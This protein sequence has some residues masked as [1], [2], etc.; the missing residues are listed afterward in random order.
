MIAVAKPEEQARVMR[1]TIGETINEIRTRDANTKKTPDHRWIVQNAGDFI[2]GI[3]R[4]RR[5]NV[6]KPKDISPGGAGSGVHLP[7]AAGRRC[8]KPI[9]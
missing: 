2:D 9:A 1:E 7:G 6:E 4:N 3:P 5:V 8:Y